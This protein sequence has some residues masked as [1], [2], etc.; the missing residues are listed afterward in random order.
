MNNIQ[1]TVENRRANQFII[2]NIYII[3]M[4]FAFTTRYVDIFV[5]R[6]VQIS[7]GIFWIGIACLN[8][9]INKFKIKGVYAE[10]IKFFLKLYLVPHVAIHVYSAILMCMGKV[11]WSYF[12]TGA[13]VYVPSLLA[14][15]SIYLFGTKAIGR[16][17]QLTEGNDIYG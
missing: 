16:N 7:I 11:S 5:D 4:I 1:N 3:S 6:A 2:K 13:T 8:L 15:V 10:D 14:I 17:V 12:T 9:L